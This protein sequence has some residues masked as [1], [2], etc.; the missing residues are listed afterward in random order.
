MR[1]EVDGSFRLTPRETFVDDL[2]AQREVLEFR[3]AHAAVRSAAHAAR[4]IAL[5]VPQTRKI[6]LLLQGRR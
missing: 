3:R 4:R 6:R 2:Q 1:I 5:A